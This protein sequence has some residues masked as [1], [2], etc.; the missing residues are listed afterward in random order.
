MELGLYGRNK[1]EAYEK[2]QKPS[3][4]ERIA[5]INFLK[6]TY[7][8]LMFFS[9]RVIVANDIMPFGMAFFAVEYL[10]RAP[11]FPTVIALSAAALSPEPMPAI[12]KC[13]I[14][15]VLFTVAARRWEIGKLP[16]SKGLVMSICVFLAGFLQKIGEGILIY[17]VAMLIFESAIIIISV[18]LFSGAKN[19]F[20]SSGDT[21]TYTSEDMICLSAFLALPLIGL[22]VPELLGIDF[23]GFFCVLLLL[24]LSYKNS[25][26]AGAVAGVTIGLIYGFYEGNTPLI[27]SSF[28][29][30]SVFCGFFGK[31]GR[32][33]AAV[34]FILAHSLIAYN[35]VPLTSFLIMLEETSFAGLVFILLPEKLLSPFYFVSEKK[36]S[37]ADKLRELTYLDISESAKAIHDVADIFASVSENRLLGTEVAVSSF[38]EKTARRLCDGCSRR[39]T[40]WRSEFHRTYTSFFVM[41]Q[42]CEKNGK[43]HNVDV[44]TDLWTKCSKRDDLC[45]AVNNMFEVYK[46]DKL[47]EIRTADSR[48][49]LSRQLKAVSD[50]LLRT[51]KSVK[52]PGAF[53]SS[54]ES[55]I[56]MYL[57]EKGIKT[58]RIFAVNNRI[59]IILEKEDE[60]I[61]LVEGAVSQYLGC[62]YHS[63]KKNKNILYLAPVQRYKVEIGKAAENKND[64]PYSGD[65]TDCMYLEGDKFFMALS[66]GMGSGERAGE[67]SRAAVRIASKMLSAG[68]DIKSTVSMINSVLVLKSCETTFATLDMA[69]LDLKRGIADFYKSGA[70]TSFIK[71][72][73]DVFP[74]SA[75][76]LPAG[77]VSHADVETS[78]HKIKDGDILFMVSDGITGVGTREEI[79]AII[80]K[81]DFSSPSDMA[82]ML[83]KSAS[84]LNANIISDDMT[85]IAARISEAG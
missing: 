67:D 44:P 50:R 36:R 73:K 82:R 75:S 29:L 58:E 28:A 27:L 49:M 3:I 13:C 70:A 69:V 72:G 16:L 48:V 65:S 14:A 39:G 33:A 19:I 12:F 10:D 71:R 61:S 80:S 25:A 74:I 24:I 68:F 55:G 43:V 47:W 8:V 1:T 46:V 22:K 77:A 81:M 32:A 9:S 45:D 11:V 38:F 56:S 53:D 37:Y 41:L 6:I 63:I 78:A 34:S 59:S 2:C 7:F 17:D 79:S 23:R 20:F 15:I 26:A 84:A 35:S 51:A 40:C 52:S 83:L 42:I 4:K 30:S 5:K 21:Q 60:N 18:H 76:S 85:V 62:E 66:D 57:S 64:N 54:K 31:Y